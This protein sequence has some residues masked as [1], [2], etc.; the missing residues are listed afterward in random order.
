[1][2]AKTPAPPYYAVI[3]SSLRTDGDQG[4]GEAASR[5]LA[6]AAEQPGFLG[7]ESARED[8]LGI[9]VSY[10]TSEAAI[11]AW[12]QQAEH[13]QARERGRATWYTAFHTRVCKV[14]RAYTYPR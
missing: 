13:R 4:Y 1:M 2:I 11:L 14:E 10:W 9:T 7:V 12:K 8:G 3:F 6:L 5:M